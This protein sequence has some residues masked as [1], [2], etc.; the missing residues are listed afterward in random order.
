MVTV[1]A[2]S[3]QK[4]TSAYKHHRIGRDFAEAQKV[5]D[6][7]DQD[8]AEDKSTRPHQHIDEQ[9]RNPLPFVAIQDSRKP[10]FLSIE[11]A[12]KLGPRRAKT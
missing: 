2:N 3:A 12:A 1:T 11:S 8:H 9:D 6:Q 5:Q 4:V 10:I 7:A